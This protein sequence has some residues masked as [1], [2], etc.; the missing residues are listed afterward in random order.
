MSVRWGPVRRLI[1]RA[2]LVRWYPARFRTT[3]HQ[4]LGELTDWVRDQLDAESRAFDARYGTSTSWFDLDNY[5]P[6]PPS[7]IRDLLDRVDPTD[8]VFVDLGSGK[9]RAVVLAAQRPF[10]KV[11]GVEHKRLLHWRAQRNLAAAASRMELRAPV[12]LVRADAADWRFPDAPTLVFLYNPFP[13]VVLRA[14]LANLRHPDTVIAYVNPLH[15][16]ALLAA[17]FEELA[18]DE[19]PAQDRCWR[20]YARCQTG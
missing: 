19:H 1:R 3:A 2:W 18:R 11:V 8:R 9:G 15:F 16:G 20:L 10:A 12:E 13:E 4:P 6:T 7:V 17:G 5:E 14:V